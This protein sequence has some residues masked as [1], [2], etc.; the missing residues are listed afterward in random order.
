MSGNKM[1]ITSNGIGSF[2][3]QRKNETGEQCPICLGKG[4]FE[5]INMPNHK[6]HRTKC[7][8]D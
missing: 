8:P 4:G 5:Y 6:T 3:D 1:D 2:R 7:T